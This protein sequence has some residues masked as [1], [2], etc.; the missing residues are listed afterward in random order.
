MVDC[1]LQARDADVDEET[2]TCKQI[3]WHGVV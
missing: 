2:Y 3:H 1:I